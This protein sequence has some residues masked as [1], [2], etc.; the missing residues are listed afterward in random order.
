METLH[1]DTATLGRELRA[2]RESLGYSQLAV[3][4]CIGTSRKFIV[5]LEAGKDNVSLA[6]TLKALAALG[7]DGPTLRTEAVPTTRFQEAFENTLSERDYEFALRLLGEYATASLEAG[8]ALMATA[9]RI[10]DKDYATALGAITRWLA[11]KT[12]TPIPGWAQ[13]IKRSDHPVFLAEKLHP[14]SDRMKQL[15][16]SDTPPEI[17]DLNVWIRE[18]DLATI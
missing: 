12:H 15:T 3:A 2:R 13:R 11:S 16:K 10:R 1:L 8:R 5:E 7:F 6:L 17:G 14:V 18:R 4:Q 9:P